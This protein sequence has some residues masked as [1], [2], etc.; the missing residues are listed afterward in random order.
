MLYI[1]RKYCS[2]CGC[3]L[4]SS[5]IIVIFLQLRGRRQ[6]VEPRKYCLV[7]VIVFFFGMCFL[8]FLFLTSWEFGLIPYI[9]HVI[10]GMDYLWQNIIHLFTNN[11]ACSNLENTKEQKIVSSTLTFPRWLH[12]WDSIYFWISIVTLNYHTHFC[13]YME[14]VTPSKIT[15]KFSP[16][17]RC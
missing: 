6:I 5:L 17:V 10:L 13:G 14:V 12:S 3:T 16:G 8:Y 1:E 15:L 9:H 7:R 4:Y 2:R 11:K